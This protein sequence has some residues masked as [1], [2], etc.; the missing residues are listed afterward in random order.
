MIVYRKSIPKGICVGPNIKA[1]FC[2][3]FSL[4]HDS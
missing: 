2:F 4:L 1:D 3:S